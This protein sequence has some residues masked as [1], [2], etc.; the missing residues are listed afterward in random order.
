MMQ[1]LLTESLSRSMYAYCSIAR[2][3]SCLLGEGIKRSLSEIDFSEDV[4]IARLNLIEG[5]RDAAAQV[6]RCKIRSGRRR[7]HLRGQGFE[8]TRFDCAVTVVIDH[9]IAKNAEEPGIGCLLGLQ[10]LNL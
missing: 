4:A 1:K 9:G 6:C 8:G 2:R 7:L 3:D 5:S 10:I